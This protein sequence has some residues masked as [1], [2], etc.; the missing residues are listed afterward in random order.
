MGSV[1]DK[2]A[3]AF[4]KGI[5]TKVTAQIDVA[6]IQ[7]GLVAKVKSD[8]TKYFQNNLEAMISQNS[9]NATF[10]GPVSP[11]FGLLS[12]IKNINTTDTGLGS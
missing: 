5:E 6:G 11:S 2:M 9:N 4:S 3:S 7:D 12:N 10:G 8:L 1:I